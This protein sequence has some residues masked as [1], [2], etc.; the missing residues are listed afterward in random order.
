MELSK[1]YF[2]TCGLLDESLITK[3]QDRLLDSGIHHISLAILSDNLSLINR[4]AYLTHPWYTHTI[5]SGSLVHAMQSIIQEDWQSLKE[6]IITYERITSTQKGKI[7]I[8]DLIYFKGMLNRDENVIRE[9]LY[10]LLKDHKKRNKHMGIAQD[11]ISIPAL[12][13]AKLA[14]LKGIEVDIDHPLLPKALLPYQPLNK[15]E[16]KYDF[17]KEL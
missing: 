11:Y 2:N 17:L 7:N 16:D 5:K 8:P 12:G 13:Y 14:W 4:Y 10:L 15:Y 3:Y 1:Q 9:A 6:D